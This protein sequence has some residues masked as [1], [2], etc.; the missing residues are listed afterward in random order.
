MSQDR[1]IAEMGGKNRGQVKDM[2]K[3]A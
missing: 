2:V 3:S 1:K